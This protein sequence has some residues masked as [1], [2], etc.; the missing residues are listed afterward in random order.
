MIF[1]GNDSKH[2]AEHPF[3]DRAVGIV[4]Q[5]IHLRAA[6]A[7][8]RKHGVPALPDRCGAHEHF[9]QP[10]GEALFEQKMIG[11]VIHTVV[12]EDAHQIGRSDKSG[13]QMILV[14]RQLVQETSPYLFQ[15]EIRCEAHVENHYIGGHRIHGETAGRGEIFMNK[16]IVN[17]VR[18]KPVIGSLLLISENFGTFRD[19]SC[20]II[21]I[22]RGNQERVGG[23][24][25]AALHISVEGKPVSVVES[26]LPQASGTVRVILPLHVVNPAPH[27]VKLSPENLPVSIM[28]VYI[29]GNDGRRLAPRGGDGAGISCGGHDIRNSAV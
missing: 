14:S 25:Y 26:A 4:V 9:I 8:V 5:G 28:Q 24:V 10:P 7:S 21:V 27:A 17:L 16:G 18:K 1:I 11:A 22:G 12:R 23:S 6:D 3:Y 20:R 2:I 29:P 19:D 15:C 13:L